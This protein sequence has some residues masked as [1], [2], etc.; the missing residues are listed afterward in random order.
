MMSVKDKALQNI[1]Q[2]HFLHPGGRGL[3]GENVL[4]EVAGIATLLEFNENYRF[5]TASCDPYI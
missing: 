5:R 3:W 2:C 4:A 1:W